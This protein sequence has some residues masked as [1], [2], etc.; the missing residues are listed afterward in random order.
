MKKRH[1][2]IGAI[3]ASAC[4]LG[5]TASKADI[6]YSWVPY[7]G[8]ATTTIGT[9]DVNSSGDVVS[10]TYYE[11]GSSG[12]LQLDYTGGL[13]NAGWYPTSFPGFIDGV[14]VLADGD[15]VLNGSLYDSATG[16]QITF[17]PFANPALAPTEQNVQNLYGTQGDWSPV[18]EP[19]TMIA[20]A[21]L[22]L[23]MGASTLRAL[24]K[25]RA[26]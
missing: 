12:T 2:L 15:A 6:I 22:L 13:N 19:T 10:L 21:F 14:K 9:L 4:L 17:T 18:P 5:A 24:R 7:S 26:A 20:G 8:N 1:K 16:D 23:P 3:A 11:T 25:N